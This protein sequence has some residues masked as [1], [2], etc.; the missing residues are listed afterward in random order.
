MSAC[1]GRTLLSWTRPAAPDHRHDRRTARAEPGRWGLHGNRFRRRPQHAHGG[2]HHDFQAFA[3]VPG[4]PGSV[5]TDPLPEA[6]ATAVVRADCLGPP[7]GHPPGDR[8]GQFLARNLAP[9]RTATAQ[10]VSALLSAAGE[11]PPA[12]ATPDGGA[13]ACLEPSPYVADGMWTG[14]ARELRARG[15]GCTWHGGC[16]PR[17]TS[18]R[19]RGRTGRLATSAGLAVV[20]ARPRNPAR[21]ALITGA[22]LATG[23]PVLAAHTGT[24][25]AMATDAS[26]MAQPDD[27]VRRHRAFLQPC[28]VR[29]S[30]GRSPV[31]GN[32]ITQLA[33]YE[34]IVLEGCDGAS[35]QTLPRPWPASMVMR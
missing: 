30:D 11:R 16:W 3:P 34:V 29:R 7:D 2:G 10:A 35:R 28:Q 23:R 32:L 4:G 9:A 8:F 6:I 26:R 15:W 31:R 17:R 14:I 25:H 5:F 33:A 1:K 22:C 27:P 19:Q 21:A 20:D 24:W 12:R 13:L 18:W